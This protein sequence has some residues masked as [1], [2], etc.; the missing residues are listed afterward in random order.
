MGVV[1]QEM[2]KEGGYEI[3]RLRGGVGVGRGV[4]TVEGV[5][6]DER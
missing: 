5:I 6:G 1:R 3:K 2:K 4:S